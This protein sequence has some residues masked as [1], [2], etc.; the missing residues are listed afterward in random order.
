MNAFKKNRLHEAVL[1]T[2]VPLAPLG[3]AQAVIPNLSGGNEA[4]LYPYYRISTQGK[5]K[6]AKVRFL[7]GKNS[8]EVLD[9]NLFLSPADVWRAPINIEK[10]S[11]N[12]D[13]TR[14]GYFE[15]FERGPVICPL[16]PYN[17]SSE[18]AINE[19]TRL[20]DSTFSTPMLIPSI[21]QSGDLP[22]THLSDWQLILNNRILFLPFKNEKED[23]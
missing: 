17:Q 20:T 19:A 6:V 15:I 2:L 11:V 9:F 12:L 7:E 22:E 13:R 10:E 18:F 8:R 21:R 23:E 16:E 4:V 14:E 3:E 5:T 1:S